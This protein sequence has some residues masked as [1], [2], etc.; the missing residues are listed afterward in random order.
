MAA[1][2]LAGT[3]KLVSFEVRRSDGQTIHP[4]GSDALGYLTYDR[5][6]HMSV[7]VMRARRPAF[8]SND[9]MGG[10]PD[11]IKAAFEGYAAY[12]GTYDVRENE[13]VV[14][15]RI[16]V[17]WFPNWVGTAQERFYEISGDRLLLRTPPTA[18]AGRDVVATLA[19][20][21]IG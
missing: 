3:W 16:T 6:G 20:K 19:W 17:S 8:S 18:Y 15:H 5:T 14:T 12:A 9:P 4:L 10:A 7:Q 1:D 2:R 13:G 21:R 11:E